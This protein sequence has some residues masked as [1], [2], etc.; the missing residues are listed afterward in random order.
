MD[1]VGDFASNE[2]DWNG[3]FVPEV[4]G[5][6]CELILTR[7]PATRGAADTLWVFWFGT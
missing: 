1:Q 5:D 6:D 7:G 3:P 2:P 4:A